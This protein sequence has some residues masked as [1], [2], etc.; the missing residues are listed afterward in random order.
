MC[1][2]VSYLTGRF[3]YVERTNA[4]QTIGEKDSITPNTKSGVTRIQAA[5]D[6][7]GLHELLIFCSVLA[8]NPFGT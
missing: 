4:Y 2:M 7:D 5:G 8:G 3:F 6:Q 1:R